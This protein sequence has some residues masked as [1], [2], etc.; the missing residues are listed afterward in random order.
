MKKIKAF[1]VA[2]VI[3]AII[4][5]F[6]YEIIRRVISD[7]MLKSN[8]VHL[9]AIVIDEKN[10]YP[11]NPVTHDFAY[12]YMFVVNGKVYTNNSHDKNAK[13]GDSVEI[14][15]AKCCPSFNRALHPT[16]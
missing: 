8:T 2:I 1:L 12:S 9:R 3:V 16:D 13:I 10:Y 4:G 6:F 14:E 11:H 15:Y 5:S 7:Y